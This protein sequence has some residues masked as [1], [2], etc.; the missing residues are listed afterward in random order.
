MDQIISQLA[1]RFGIDEALAHKAVGMVLALLQRQGDGSAVSEL[2]SKLP[3]AGDLA[4]QY[5][6]AGSG[7]GMAGTLGG[8]LGGGTGEAMK[9]I[10]AL[11][12]DGLSLD[13]IKG[14]GS[15]LLDH[16]RQEAG[17]DL[18]RSAVSGIPGVSDYL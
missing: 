7:G 2:F 3:G 4:G 6:E 18:V 8:L 5:A 13:Q 16:A 1:S 9:L 11:Q 14:I 12:S 17:E 10:G 15:G